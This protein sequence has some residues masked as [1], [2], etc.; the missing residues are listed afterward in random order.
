M[1]H[2]ARLNLRHAC[3]HAKGRNLTLEAGFT[4]DFLFLQDLTSLLLWLGGVW[5][6]WTSSLFIRLLAT[7]HRYIL[8]VSLSY[9]CGIGGLIF[10]RQNSSPNSLDSDWRSIF[11]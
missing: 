8:V 3:M 5:G 10:G 11:G 7:S 2:S 4:Q 6:E 1:L 9:L